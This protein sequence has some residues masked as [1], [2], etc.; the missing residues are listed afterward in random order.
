L[1]VIDTH[2]HILPPSILQE[3]ARVVSAFPNISVEKIGDRYAFGFPDAPPTSPVAE[4]F[5]PEGFVARLDREGMTAAVVSPWTDLLGYGLPAN[6]GAAWARLQNEKMMELVQA[7]P[8]LVPMATVPL[9]DGELA[10]KEVQAASDMGFV[11][12][13][14]GTVA[15]E[16]ELDDPALA[17]FWMAADEDEMPVF[18]HPVVP[19]TG[20]RDDR[21]YGLTNSV[22]RIVYTTVA[23]TRLLFSGTLARLP[24]LRVLVAHGGASIPY[25]LGRLR[26]THEI[27]PDTNADPL[28]AFDR[29]YFDTVV[30]DPKALR[31]LIDV[32]GR[33]RVLLGSDYP[34]PNREPAPLDFVEDAVDDE[35]IRAAI[36][37]AN[38]VTLFKL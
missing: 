35:D 1:K 7:E 19:K 24:R 20:L 27:G 13:E 8:Y 38:A 21:G 5:D 11:A 37:G 22:G 6:E 28:G 3:W 23:L 29:L 2:A 32:A 25:I 17:A 4:L 31:F 9:Q 30:F 26:R 18:L 33:D 10:A 15:G 16:R 12:I 34:F 36:L 14:I